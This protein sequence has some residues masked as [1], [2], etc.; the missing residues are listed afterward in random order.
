MDIYGH[1]CKVLDS[2]DN[3]NSLPLS[4]VTKTMRTQPV[5]LL[6]ELNDGHLIQDNG[7]DSIL[8]INHHQ[9]DPTN[10]FNL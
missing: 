2:K 9:I 8:I 1:N 3:L 6:S 7:T 4:V 5:T 10:Y